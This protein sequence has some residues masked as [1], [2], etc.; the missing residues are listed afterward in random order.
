MLLAASAPSPHRL[1]LHCA[2]SGNCLMLCVARAFLSSPTASAPCALAFSSES[3][4]ELAVKNRADDCHARC[5]CSLPVGTHEDGGGGGVRGREWRCR[6]H[7]AVDGAVPSGE[8]CAYRTAPPDVAGGSGGRHAP[9]SRLPLRPHARTHRS[10]GRERAP[11]TDDAFA[12]FPPFWC[13]VREFGLREI[14]ARWWVCCWRNIGGRW[15]VWVHSVWESKWEGRV[16]VEAS[17]ALHAGHLLRAF[18]ACAC[19]ST[20]PFSSSGKVRGGGVPK[21]RVGYW[22]CAGEY[23]RSGN[24]T[25]ES[26]K[27]IRAGTRGYWWL[28]QLVGGI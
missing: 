5:V 1:Q 14:F 28:R 10:R 27:A 6:R 7:Q 4:R 12:M 11:R 3:L 17:F 9:L 8:G 22:M 19:V 20:W 21:C 15:G 13:P 23:S 26:G 16:Q 25:Q 18:F 24:S 2:S